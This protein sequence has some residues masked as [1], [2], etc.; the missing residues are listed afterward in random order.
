MKKKKIVLF[1]FSQPKITILI[2]LLII[3]SQYKY[4]I[5]LAQNS[6]KHFIKHHIIAT[7]A[8]DIMFINI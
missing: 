1:I 5:Y 6:L 8:L 7:I 2:L 3:F 4:F